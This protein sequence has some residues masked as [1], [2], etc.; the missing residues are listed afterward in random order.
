MYEVLL[1]QIPFVELFGRRETRKKIKFAL[2]L[3][4]AFSKKKS[5]KFCENNKGREK[6]KGR[7]AKKSVKTILKK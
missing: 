5:I 7:E 6:K 2:T 4:R 3:S 1:I